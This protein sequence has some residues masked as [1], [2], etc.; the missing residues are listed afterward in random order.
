MYVV[1]VMYVGFVHV[2]G[3]FVCMYCTCFFIGYSHFSIT[4]SLPRHTYLHEVSV[5][6]LIIMRTSSKAF[7]AFFQRDERV[8]RVSLLISVCTFHVSTVVVQEGVELCLPPQQLS[9][10]VGYGAIHIN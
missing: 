2:C 5:P 8:C 4:Y 1:C 9:L 6:Q 7:R 10:K 3:V